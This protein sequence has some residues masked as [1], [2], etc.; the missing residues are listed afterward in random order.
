MKG[1]TTQSGIAE[2]IRFWFSSFWMPPNTKR[3]DQ[4]YL[5]QPI[6]TG[7]TNSMNRQGSLT[8]LPV[9]KCYTSKTPKCFF[10]LTAIHL[11]FGRVTGKHKGNFKEKLQFALGVVGVGERGTWQVPGYC[12]ILLDVIARWNGDYTVAKTWQC[13]TPK[14]TPTNWAGETCCTLWDIPQESYNTFL[15]LNFIYYYYLTTDSTA[16]QNS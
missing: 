10:W 8:D 11:F 9:A 6:F 3:P 15:V 7:M 14:T 4:E 5:K 12:T 2:G 13:A 16:A 1:I